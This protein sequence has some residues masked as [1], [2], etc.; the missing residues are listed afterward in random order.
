MQ[1]EKTCPIFDNLSAKTITLMVTQKCNLSCVYCYE[2]DKNGKDMTF[3][4]A[5]EIIDREANLNDGHTALTVDFFGGE[6][7][8]NFK[9]IKE[10]V[11]YYLA[12]PLK[13]PFRFFMTTNGTL[14][15]GE[16]K[17]WLLKHSNIVYCGL[18][19]DGNKKVQDSNRSNSF[20]LIDLDF[21]LKTYPRQS[22]KMT[23]YP[24]TIQYFAESVIE[25]HKMGFFIACNLAYGVDWS[26]DKHFELFKEQLKV[27]C[28]FYVLNPNIKPCTML[29]RRL[30]CLTWQDEEEGKMQKWCGVKTYMR[31][32]DIDGKCYPCQH[33]MPVSSGKFPPLLRE[34]MQIE[35]KISLSLIDE[36]CRHCKVKKLC[37]TCYGANY[38]STGN[39]YHRDMS[40]CRYLKAHF[41]ACSYL[42]AKLILGGNLVLTDAEKSNYARGIMV[43]QNELKD[44]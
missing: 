16:I 34:D 7:L 30:D 12:N 1:K 19:L 37:P 22:I 14:V 18:S 2:H 36:E 25:L 17:E 28:D 6:P 3:E 10:I 35:E 5:T 20:D 23:L 29:D 40:L 41:L 44:I 11:E 32:Y 27:L 43:I 21:F 33:F 24:A 38:V 42:S 39:Y 15:H 26:S 4:Q 8:M 13:T 9:L 31:V